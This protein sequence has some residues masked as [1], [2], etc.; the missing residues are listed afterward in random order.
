VFSVEYMNMN[1]RIYIAPLRWG[2]QCC[3]HM[4]TTW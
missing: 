1:M 2:P 4:M 3:V